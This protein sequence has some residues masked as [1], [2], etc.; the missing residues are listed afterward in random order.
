MPQIQEISQQLTFYIKMLH[1]LLTKIHIHNIPL[2]IKQFMSS[3]YAL[4]IRHVLHKPSLGALRYWY[5]TIT[6]AQKKM[7]GLL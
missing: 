5:W 3:V 2:P 6:K 1:T 7:Y 4:G